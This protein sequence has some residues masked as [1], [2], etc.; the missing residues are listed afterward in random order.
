[1]PIHLD[2]R[3][4]R[5]FFRDSAIL[6]LAPSALVTGQAQ[7]ATTSTWALLADTHIAADPEFR[8]RDTHL[9]DN[10]RA[11]VTDLLKEKESLSGVLIDGDC[12]YNDG[13]PGDYTTLAAI[14]QPLADAKIPIHF[15]LGNHDN[16]ETFYE[17][18]EGHTESSALE[19]KHCSVIETPQAD[20]ILLDT[21]RFVNKVEGE[22]GTE[23]REWLRER[24]RKNPE[25][26]ALLVGHH[27][28]QVVREDVIP[29]EKKIKIAGLI[30]SREFLDTLTENPAAKAYI[31]G[32]SHSW[33]LKKEP[34]GVHLVNLP[35][36]AYVF[37]DGR[38][39]GWV[40]ATLSPKGMQLE[41]RCINQDHPLHGELKELSWR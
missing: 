37:K 12:A 36:T 5:R 15:T 28:P 16:R 19:S 8:A 10:L 7:A 4:R 23:Q 35:P 34:S 26:P 39:N 41:L 2:P 38:P 22:L 24:L 31:Y 20:W 40:R 30:D 33:N 32:H 29:S 6:T 25:K 1:M 17:A 13:Q 9:A 3:S 11:V 27:Y 21:L 14:L 18:F